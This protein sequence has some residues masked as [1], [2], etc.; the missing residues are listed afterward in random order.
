[1]E[2]TVRD[3][4]VQKIK[5]RVSLIK[6][7]FLKQ[8]KE[9]EHNRIESALSQDDIKEGEEPPQD[10]LIV[11]F[12]EAFEIYKR[13]KA[14]YN[15]DQELLKIR[16][17]E[18]KKQILDELREL[19]NTDES[20]K[21]TY[22]RFKELQTKWKE[23]GLVPTTE[24]NNLWQNYHFL[25]EKF[26]DKVKISKELR[27][28][29]LKKNLEL[30]LE[31]CEKA[32][33]LLLETSIIKSFKQLQKYHDEWKEVG[34][35]PQDKRDELWERFKT[36]TDKINERRREYYNKLSEQQES[37]LLAK[38]ALLEKAEQILG[39]EINSIKEW[40]DATN[41]INE[42]FKVWKT[43]GPAPKKNN[44]EIWEKFKGALNGFFNNKKEYFSGIKQEQLNNFNLKLDICKQAENLKDSTDWKKTTQELINLQREWKEIGP[45][46][47]K[48]SDKIWKRFR[49]ACDEFFHNKSAFFSNIDQMEA[50]N[51]EK[52]LGLI[53]RIQEYKY[54]EDKNA[55]LEIL[56]GFQREWTEIGHVP[57]KEKDKI[58]IS[59]REAINKQLDKLNISSLEMKAIDF[60]NKMDSLVESPNAG[61]A[62]RKEIG[63]L[64]GKVSKLREDIHLWENNIGFLAHSKKADLLKA[65][66]EKKIEK[67]KEELALSEAKLRYMQDSID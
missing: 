53:G 10:P 44:D 59:F 6:V 1:M 11:R 2:E 17:L 30:K 56:K 27:D 48:H 42:L 29:D 26:F 25:V 66:F 38:N 60:K 62:I 58:H 18:S 55:N 7:A 13:N 36:A 67:A 23:I 20:L 8:T 45:V 50:E 49:A 65:E 4:D 5:T 54:S 35:V 16:N 43:V 15:E 47:R 57:I 40:Q 37:N 39:L 12:N 52:K 34:P 19:V 21:K 32:E 41:Q 31:L 22:D 9:L 51:L 63:F 14:K 24:I 64:S 33:E 3:T 61:R 46:P 28:L